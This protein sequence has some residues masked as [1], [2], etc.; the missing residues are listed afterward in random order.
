MNYCA[1][2]RSQ[3]ATTFRKARHKLPSRL[4]TPSEW[5]QAADYYSWRYTT[6][7]K[8]KAWS[9]ATL[10][11]NQLQRS[12]SEL[13]TRCPRGRSTRRTGHSATY[14]ILHLKKRGSC[15][16]RKRHAGL[17]WTRTKILF[18]ARLLAAGHP[19][20]FASGLSTAQCSKPSHTCRFAAFDSDSV[21]LRIDNCCT[22]CITNSLAD[23]WLAHQCPS[24]LASKGSPGEKLWSLPSAQSSGRSKTTM[25]APT[26]FSFQLALLKECAL[27]TA[28]APATLG[29]ASQRPP[30]ETRGDMVWNTKRSS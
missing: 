15:V 14:Y 25:A 3:P 20:A 27:S 11:W 8:L 4:W 7:L 23:T 16:G 13:C 29:P 12:V 19:S 6:K 10:Y 9:T 21:T 24:Q 26:L 1:P 5:T 18:L 22:A 17:C 2:L 28:V 30:A